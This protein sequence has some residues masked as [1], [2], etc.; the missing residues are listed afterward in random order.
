M[1]KK[2]EKLTSK[3]DSSN[4]LLNLTAKRAKH[5][6]IKYGKS[7]DELKDCLTQISQRASRGKRGAD[8]LQ[9]WAHG[10]VF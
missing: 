9:A 5:M 3:S 6:A 1:I 10:Q 4:E 8:G 2:L 7:K